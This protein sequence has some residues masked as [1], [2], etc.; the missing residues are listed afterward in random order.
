LFSHLYQRP[1]DFD[2]KLRVVCSKKN[3][4]K[5]NLNIE[6][7]EYINISNMS[8][9]DSLTIKKKANFGHYPSKFNPGFSFF[10]DIAMGIKPMIFGNDSLP[11][12]LQILEE[13]LLTE[14]TDKLFYYYTTQEEFRY[15]I[16]FLVKHYAQVCDFRD[17]HLSEQVT[18]KE[19]F[20]VVKGYYGL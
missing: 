19:F 18:T 8:Y 7:V 2:G 12:N 17:K 20:D 3:S 11:Y 5:G 9:G 6:N 10:E 13:Y 1:L 4:I 14:E 15:D 16:G